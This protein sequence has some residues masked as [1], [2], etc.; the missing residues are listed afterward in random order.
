MKG[1]NRLQLRCDE[2][3]GADCRISV[4]CVKVYGR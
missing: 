4:R 3:G 1:A 2:L